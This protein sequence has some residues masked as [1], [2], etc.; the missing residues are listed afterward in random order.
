MNALCLRDPARQPGVLPAKSSCFSQRRRI[1]PHV[2][3]KRLGMSAGRPS[4]PCATRESS[5]CSAEAWSGSRLSSFSETTVVARVP[6]GVLCLISALAFHE[7][8]TQV[9]H[10]IDVALERG[11]REP[12]LDYPP[13]RFF[14]FWPR[15]PHRRTIREDPELAA[16]SSPSAAPCPPPSRSSRCSP[17]TARTGTC[18]TLDRT[19][20][21]PGRTPE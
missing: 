5:T 1:A 12:R 20:L 2:R 13:T 14:W 6:Q 11:T 3:A 15:W 8:I 4:T 7:L 9:P 17:R 18:N 16:P 21:W 19:P 10:A